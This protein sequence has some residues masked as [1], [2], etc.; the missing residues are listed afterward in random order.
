MKVLLVNDY[1]TPTAGAEIM[2]LIFRDTLR[3]RGHEVR[4]FSSSTQLVPGPLFADATCFGTTSRFQALTSTFN[5]SAR[6]VLAR[7]IKEFDPD[8][9]HV[10]M[11]LWQLSPSILSVLRRVPAVYQ[12]VT[13]KPICPNGRKTLPNGRSCENSPGV[14]CL[15]GGCLTPQSWVAMMAQHWL[16]RRSRGVFDRFVTSS[17]AMQERLEAEGVGPCEVIPLGCPVRS[18]R[19]AL[20]GC[21]VIG[22]AGRLS[23]EKGVDVLISAFAFTQRQLPN[24][25]LW[26]AGDG[27]EADD[28]KELARRLGIY[29]R[30]EFLGSLDREELERRFD[31]AW[32]QVVPSVWDEP[33]GIAAIEAMM[34]G[35]AVVA[36]DGGGL[37]EIVRHNKTGLLVPPSNERELAAALVRLTSDRK[38]C[39][40][41]GAAGRAVAIQEYDSSAYCDRMLAIFEQVLGR[42]QRAE[43]SDH[44]RMSGAG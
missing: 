1:A 7:T 4:V 39:E 12:I 2:T 25:K 40:T 17:K 23:S 3:S 31:D 24:A 44:T 9:V 42:S 38:L 6:R 26:I 16:W 10:T 8:M 30:I 36:S 18:A 28:L 34:R 41:M 22:Y 37:R 29:D 20:S 11:F 21:P 13:Y 32:V 14:V 5:V 15:L 43:L 35:T 27:R 19:P 33:F